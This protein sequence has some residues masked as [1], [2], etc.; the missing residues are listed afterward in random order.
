M[1]AR[2]SVF[3]KKVYGIQKTIQDL[4]DLIRCKC[5]NDQYKWRR[6]STNM[7]F[8]LYRHHINLGSVWYANK[9][10]PFLL[11]NVSETSLIRPGSTDK[12]ITINNIMTMR[13]PCVFGVI[14]N[15]SNEYTCLYLDTCPSYH[16]SLLWIMLPSLHN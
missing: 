15:S 7:T 13:L 9:T 2:D 1:R 6:S 5:T 12:A 4:Y 14:S 11:R 3:E 10:L 16:H 8:T